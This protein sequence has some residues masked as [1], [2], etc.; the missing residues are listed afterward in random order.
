[1]PE[2]KPKPPL[3]FIHSLNRAGVRYAITGSVAETLYFEPSPTPGIDFLVALDEQNIKLLPRIFP[4]ATFYVPRMEAIAA[5]VSRRRGGHFDIAHMKTGFKATFYPTGQDEMNAWALQN[6][7]TVT[8]ERELVVAAPPE[9][10]IVT[11]LESYRD[12]AS[13]KHLRDIRL[14]LAVSGNQ[15]DKSELDEWIHRRG[16]QE[17]WQK[18]QS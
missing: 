3:L 13:D 6:K 1:M 10:L 12:G 16:L 9:Y 7:R 17:Q 4:A 15:I 14:M 5:E 8:F 18:I 2:P 11:K